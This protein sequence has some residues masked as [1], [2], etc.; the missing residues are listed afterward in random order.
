MRS[1][2]C[3]SDEELCRLRGAQGLSQQTLLLQSRLQ[4]Y[5]RSPYTL[6]ETT[7]GEKKS[8]A[9][10]FCSL[11]TPFS[12]SDFSTAIMGSSACNARFQLKL[13][14]ESPIFLLRDFLQNQGTLLLSLHVAIAQERK[15]IN[16]NQQHMGVSE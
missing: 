9:E 13:L 15:R 7:E 3:H 10:S 14:K 5:M 11:A 6:S 12:R 16:T 8:A 4:S 2:G 1:R